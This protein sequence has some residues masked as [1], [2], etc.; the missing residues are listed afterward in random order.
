MSVQG[1]NEEKIRLR[2][3]EFVKPLLGC[4][5]LTPDDLNNNLF[6]GHCFKQEFIL[7]ADAYRVVSDHW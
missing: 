5:Q 7:S 4:K 1:V 3:R 2:F 6:L